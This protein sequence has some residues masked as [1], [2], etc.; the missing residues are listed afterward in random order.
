M[1]SLE[2]L[3]SVVIPIYNAEPYL[4]ECLNSVKNQTYQNLEVILVNDGSTDRSLSICEEIQ[5]SDSR[6]RVFNRTNHGVGASR[7]FGMS[8]S[9]GN[10][11]CFVDSDDYCD[12]S[13]ITNLLSPLE[14]DAELDVS[15][16]GIKDVVTFSENSAKK[17]HM[18]TEKKYSVSDYAENILLVDNIDVFCGAPYGKMYRL[19]LLKRGGIGFDEKATYAEDFIFN[20]DVLKASENIYILGESLYNYRLD[21]ETS[22]THVNHCNRPPEEY[23]VQR[24][25]AYMAF[26]SVFKKCD[27]YNAYEMQINN[28]LLKFVISSERYL[29]RSS[30]ELR[31]K[32]RIADV[33]RNEVAVNNCLKYPYQMRIMDRLRRSLLKNGHYLALNFLENMTK[34]FSKWK[35]GTL[36]Q[37]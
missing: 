36:P 4:L 26:E 25:N 7:N 5:K 33:I 29:F 9:N 1:R 14:K 12:Q 16:C 17:R 20:M 31:E 23:W 27:L 8:C 32:K 2:P 21:V 3:V 30:L 10:Y 28:L 34:F 11:I 24:L 35:G 19:D 13:M 37:V 15:I 18:H 6:F 22:L